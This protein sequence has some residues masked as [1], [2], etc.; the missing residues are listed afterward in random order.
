MHSK[1]LFVKRVIKKPNREFDNSDKTNYII[2]FGNCESWSWYKRAIAEATGIPVSDQR[3]IH[4]G[5]IIKE[6]NVRV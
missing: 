5:K 3:L 6:D 1:I 2:P 4:A